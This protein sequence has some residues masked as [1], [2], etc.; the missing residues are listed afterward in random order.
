MDR[1]E[2]SIM[3]AHYIQI[4]ELLCEALSHHC[5]ERLQLVMKMISGFEDRWG[6]NFDPI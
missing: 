4:M 6:V 5:N 3:A 2:L 1:D